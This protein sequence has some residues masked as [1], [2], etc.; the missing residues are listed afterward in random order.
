MAP[1]GAGAV[2]DK[3]AGGDKMNFGWDKHGFARKTGVPEIDSVL[4]GGDLQDA[5]DCNYAPVGVLA[6]L[7]VDVSH[8]APEDQYA[9]GIIWLES[10]AVLERGRSMASVWA[11]TRL[12]DGHREPCNGSCRCCQAGTGGHCEG[13]STCP[14]HCPISRDT[15]RAA[16]M[17]A[18]R[19]CAANAA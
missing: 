10:G 4:G 8:G 18:E 1:D 9:A 17:L 15:A 13:H 7:G 5:Q 12:P 3:R 11:C 16:G 14:E 19:P 6:D 2:E